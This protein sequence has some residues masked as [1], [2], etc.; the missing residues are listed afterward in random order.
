[1]PDKEK[2]LFEKL[3]GSRYGSSEGCMCYDM[4][5]FLTACDVSE[6]EIKK[7]TIGYWKGCR[8]LHELAISDNNAITV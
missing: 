2:T 1:M 4:I 3:E 7:A 6:A 8:Y 5:A